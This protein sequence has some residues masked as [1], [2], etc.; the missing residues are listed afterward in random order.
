MSAAHAPESSHRARTARN[1]MAG[2]ARERIRAGDFA[3][4]DL[5]RR[6]FGAAPLL[7]VGPIAAAPESARPFEIQREAVFRHRPRRARQ[8][9]GP[10]ASTGRRQPV[11]VA[12]RSTSPAR[13]SH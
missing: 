13:T 11:Y 5:T 2:L 3:V 12:S 4:G 6:I 1:S 10:R 9:N 8:E 7:F